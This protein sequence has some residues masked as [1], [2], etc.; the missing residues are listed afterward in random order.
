M[1]LS[2]SSSTRPGRHGAAPSAPRMHAPWYAVDAMTDDA[3]T[4][5][6]AELLAHLER[7]GQVPPAWTE[8]HAPDGSLARVW[9]ATTDPLSLVL[10]VMRARGATATALAICAA[11]RAEL[12]GLPPSIAGERLRG[13]LMAAEAWVRGV[14]PR[15]AVEDAFGWLDPQ[16][17][18]SCDESAGDVTPH[19][20]ALGLSVSTLLYFVVD[21]DAGEVTAA[22]A[23]T[24]L[25]ESDFG[26]ESLE[27]VQKLLATLRAV[28]PRPTLAQLRA[29][30][31]R[32]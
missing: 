19:A 14:T 28:L 17:L 7:D 25:A 10:A 15:D 26:P 31:E 32:G 30:Y 11:G 5:P 9:V 23:A 18:W 2:G 13:A 27:A 3:A 6:L 22:E 8:L 1:D 20:H 29:A 24:S 4:D 21:V 16:E 12:A